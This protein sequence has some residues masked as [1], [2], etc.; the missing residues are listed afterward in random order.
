MGD[1]QP[2]PEQCGGLTRSR[3][4][5][6]A[7]AATAAVAKAAITVLAE[8][9][10]GAQPTPARAEKVAFAREQP[11]RTRKVNCARSVALMSAFRLCYTLRTQYLSCVRDSASRAYPLDSRRVR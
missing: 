4:P 3:R 7:A 6:K 5:Y 8:K 11:G 10:L 1:K 9:R 2:N